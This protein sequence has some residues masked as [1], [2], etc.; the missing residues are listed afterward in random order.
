MWLYLPGSA[1]SRGSAAAAGSTSASE[2]P[3]PDPRLW[4]TSSGKPTQQ[5]L[6]WRGWRT[7]PWIRLLFGTTLPPSRASSIAE[8]WIS[9]WRDSPAPQPRS[10]EN[11]KESRT[12]GGYGRSSPPPFARLNPDGSFSKT[13]G[14]FSQL[15][16]E[17]LSE[18]F[19]ETWPASGSMRT[20]FVS[21]RATWAP[22]MSGSACSSWPTPRTITGGAESA[23][24]K[25]EL[26]RE[27]SGGGDLQ[28]AVE[29][30]P[31][32]RTRSRASDS[33]SSTR[34]K[35]GPNPGLNDAVASWPTPSARD[36]KGRDIPNHHGGASLAHFTQTGQRYHSSPQDQATP[37]GKPSPDSG[38]TSRLRLNPAF[39]SWLMGAPWWWTRAERINYA[40]AEMVSW[41]SKARRLL[42]SLTGA[43]ER[44]L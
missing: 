11:G 37:G 6:S 31:T 19:S 13:S 32:P 5:P 36:M 40:S 21:R 41:L 30:W 14:D 44:D 33:G 16:L 43:S 20:G 22:R 24:R 9:S 1:S 4:V 23:E 12:S 27:D 34:K 42:L 8:Q 38:P 39:V 26:G 2:S 29:K 15:T 35:E 10:Q 18:E 25:K 28:A 17:G 3:S 7:R